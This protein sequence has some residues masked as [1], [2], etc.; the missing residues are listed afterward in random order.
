MIYLVRVFDGLLELYLW[1]VIIRAVLSW[2]R[3]NP[4]NPLVRMVCRL[5][6]PVTGF[7][8]RY[9][10]ARVGVVDV[11]PLILMVIIMIVRRVAVRLLAGIP[12]GF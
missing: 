4:F 9:I 8:A 3:P 11:S 5:V 2:F 10:P 7:I 12:L 6:D 1:I